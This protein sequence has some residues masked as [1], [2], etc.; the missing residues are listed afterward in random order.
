MSQG[1]CVEFRLPEPGHVLATDQ[2]DTSTRF[3][4]V[5]PASFGRLLCRLHVD[6]GRQ[7][8]FRVDAERF[9]PTSLG[10]TRPAPRIV[11]RALEDIPARGRLRECLLP[12]I[13]QVGDRSNTWPTGLS[14]MI[15]IS[16]IIRDGVCSFSWLSSSE[17]PAQHNGR[18]CDCGFSEMI[19]M[20]ILGLEYGRYSYYGNVGCPP[21]KGYAANKHTIIKY[22][23]NC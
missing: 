7:R 22:K 12:V 23:E 3:V 19:N 21:V 2:S 4:C 9:W 1:A 20:P 13:W 15:N 5:D 6:D 14:G 11:I 8:P 18:A 17:G 16:I 10:W